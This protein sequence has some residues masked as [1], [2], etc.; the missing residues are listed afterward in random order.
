M[1]AYFDVLYKDRFEELFKGT[2]IY[3][4]PT[5]ERGKY[6]VLTFNFSVVDPD[7]DKMGE[8]F[9]H[10]TRGRALSFLRKYAEY[11]IKDL[12]YVRKVVEE[13]RSASDILHGG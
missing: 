7:S 6:L 8:S 3:E 4:H 9:L 1:E 2:W 12:E 13:S 10:H 5:D 11:L